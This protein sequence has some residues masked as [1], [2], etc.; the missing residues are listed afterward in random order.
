MRL[1]NMSSAIFQEAF[2]KCLI[3]TTNKQNKQKKQKKKQS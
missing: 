2:Q 3:A 1:P